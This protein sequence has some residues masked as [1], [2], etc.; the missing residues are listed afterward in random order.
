MSVVIE[1]VSLYQV[2][3]DKDLSNK[4]YNFALE[5]ETH[6][7]IDYI[8]IINDVLATIIKYKQRRGDLSKQQLESLVD[9]V[10]NKYIPKQQL[11]KQG[12][13]CIMIDNMYIIYQGSGKYIL[14]P[15]QVYATKY[16]S[17]DDAERGMREL[18]IEGKILE[19]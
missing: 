18:W 4:I 9:R 13:Y 14:T 1:E 11:V 16:I 6:M 19:V 8:H 3:Y 12:R 15:N 7:G 5:A 2:T 17:L 10:L